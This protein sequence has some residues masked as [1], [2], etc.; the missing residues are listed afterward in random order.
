MSRERVAKLAESWARE[1]RDEHRAAD[2]LQGIEA[3][4][5]RMRAT[6][7]EALASELASAVAAEPRRGG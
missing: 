1:A 4:L 3:K 7:R 2:R 6:T 5:A